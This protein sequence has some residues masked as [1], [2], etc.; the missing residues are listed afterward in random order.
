ML[1]QHNKRS[2]LDRRSGSE[3]RTDYTRSF[4]C[5]PFDQRKGSDRRDEEELRSSWVRVSKYSS[6]YLGFPVKDLH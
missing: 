6:A 5:K 1:G 4:F 3:R 2:G